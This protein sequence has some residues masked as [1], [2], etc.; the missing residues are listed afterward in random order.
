MILYPLIITN[1]YFLQWY[2]DIHTWDPYVSLNCFL[3]SIMGLTTMILV[4][5]FICISFYHRKCSLNFFF[6]QMIM[7]IL[8]FKSINEDKFFFFFYWKRIFR[9]HYVS[10]FFSEIASGYFIKI[11]MLNASELGKEKVIAVC[12]FTVLIWW[13]SLIYSIQ[14]YFPDCL[15]FRTQCMKSLNHVKI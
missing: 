4:Y 13:H 5:F 2:K 1:V 12:V 14:T 7:Y 9:I 11:E 8:S 6:S 3:F 15:L 10:L